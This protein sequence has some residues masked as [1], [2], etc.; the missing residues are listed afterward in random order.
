[1]EV[2]VLGIWRYLS[3]KTF[4]NQ[5]ISCTFANGKLKV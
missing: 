4:V 3:T 2:K 5:T 1:M